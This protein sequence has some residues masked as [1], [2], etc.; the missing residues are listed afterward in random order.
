MC[1][2]DI[3]FIAV[4]D[5][6]PNDHPRLHD[7]CGFCNATLQMGPIFE[8]LFVDLLRKSSI[9]CVIR[10]VILT[11][12]HERAKNLGIPMVVFATPSAIAMQCIYHLPPFVETVVLPIPAHPLAH[13]STPSL[14]P[15]KLTLGI[16]RSESEIAARQAPLACLPG[17]SPTMRVNDIPKFLLSHDLDTFFLRFFR[18]YQNPTSA[19]L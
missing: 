5:G 17:G 8:E 16:P 11:A 10:D 19:R 15:V 6:L 12:A 4:P 1:S 9:T 3:E 2:K 14:D 18:E 7:L 13:V